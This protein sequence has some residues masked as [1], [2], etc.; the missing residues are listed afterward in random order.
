M[1]ERSAEKLVEAIAQSRHTSLQRLLFALGIPGVGESTALSLA[2]HFGALRG[3]QTATLEQI[4][5]VEDVGPTI[6]A[7]IERF[8]ADERHRREVAR[9]HEL[10]E[11]DE[12]GPSR[13]Q[14]EQQLAGLI[15]V[16]TGALSGITR[17]QATQALIA[18]GARVSG[19]VSAKTSYVVAGTDPGSKLARAEALGVPVLDE[20]G[21]RELLA[22]R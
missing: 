6:G 10:L 1:G 14:A 2:K 21:L 19:S 8:F 17:E 15:V 20:A 3:L 9:L 13:P 18:Q 4:C 5:E 16:L 12:P 22:R 11:F 7:S